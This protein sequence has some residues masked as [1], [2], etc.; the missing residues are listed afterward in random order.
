MAGITNEQINQIQSSANIV[1]IISEYVTLEKKGKNYFGL[2]PFHDDNHP[3]M[4]VSEDKGIYTCFVCHKTGNVFNFIKDYENISFIEAVRI[5][6]QKV[7]IEVSEEVKPVSKYESLYEINEYALKYYQNNLKTKDGTKALEYLKQRKITDD[8]IN[9]FGIGYALKNTNSLSS[10]L[11]NKYDENDLIA[12]GIANYGNS[13]YDLFRNRIT[14]PIHNSS[15]RCVGFS[16]RIYEDVDEAK[17]VNTKETPIFKKGEILFNYH[18]AINEAK[19]KKQ[20]ILVEGQMDAIRVYSEGIKNVIATMGTALTTNHIKLLKKLNVKVILCMDS[21]NAGEEATKINGELLSNAGIETLVLRLVGAKDPD[22][23]LIK[24]GADAFKDAV[25]HAITFF[26]FKINTFKNNKNFN[27]VDDLAKYIND[28]AAY[29][30]K[31]NDEVLINITV[32]K[33]A[34]E[35]NIDKNIILNKIIKVETVSE[36]NKVIYEQRKL[37]KNMKLCEILLYYM[38]SDTKY[39]QLYNQELS[40]IPDEKYDAIAQDIL[41]F[42]IKYNYIN[43]ADFITHEIESDNYELILKIIDNNINVELIDNDFIGIIDKI[44]KWLTENKINELKE[45][46]KLTVD[47]NEKLKITDQI[48]ELKKRDVE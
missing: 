34:E 33:L 6:A 26:D 25:S 2:C 24:N 20:I 31:S 32:N 42:F 11:I 14:F 29:L 3:S 48:A 23:Y 12:S 45:K 21:D 5:V 15:G 18:R 43:I 35:Y 36:P 22:E 7:G 10:I 37:T 1:D 41:A 39:I 28:V 8:I 46:L 9:E 17:Y 47:I 19:L 27:K 30:S 13:L 38:M 16:S 4:S 40:Y 44:K